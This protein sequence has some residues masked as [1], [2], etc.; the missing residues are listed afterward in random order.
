MPDFLS[1]G[2]KQEKDGANRKVEKVKTIV[3]TSLVAA[4][5]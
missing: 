2:C 3:H 5:Q 1:F 4:E